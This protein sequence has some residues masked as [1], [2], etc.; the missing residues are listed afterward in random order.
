AYIVKHGAQMPLLWF[1]IYNEPQYGLY[2]SRDTAFSLS[3]W[4][5]SVPRSIYDQNISLIKSAI[6]AGETYQVNYTIRLHS[7]FKGNDVSFYRHL[8]TI[9]KAPFSA[10]LNLGRY[11]II[12]VS[13]ELFFRWD[14]NSIMA[15][16]MKGTYPRG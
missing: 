9:Q 2:P 5:P 8:S 14:Q 16:P 15:K 4:V 6:S 7:L 12:S 3:K 10:Y 13:P 1:S 11:R